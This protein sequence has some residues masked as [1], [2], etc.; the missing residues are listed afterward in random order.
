MEKKY[1]MCSKLV[2]A[3]AKFSLLKDVPIVRHFHIST[4]IKHYLRDGCARAQSI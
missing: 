3:L 4:H 1:C 2:V